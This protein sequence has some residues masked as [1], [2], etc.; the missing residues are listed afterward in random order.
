[1]NT[2]FVTETPNANPLPPQHT[3]PTDDAERRVEQFICDAGLR[4]LAHK[5]QVNLEKQRMPLGLNLFE[6]ISDYYYRETL[7][8][9]ILHAFLDPAGKHQA[10]HTYLY[11]FLEFLRT[12]HSVKID[13]AHYC[14]VVVEKEK[15]RIDIL[16]R[17]EVSKRAIIIENKINGAA[18]QHRQLPGYLEYLEKKGYTCDAIVYLRLTEGAGPDTK[19]WT[20]HDRRQ[21]EAV[22]R[23]VCAYDGSEGEKAL[24]N[25]WILK[26]AAVA[27]DPDTKHILGQYGA[28]IKKLGGD[29]MNKP[30]MEQFYSIIMKDN[31]FKTALSL[32]QML[33]ELV[34]YRVQRIVDLFQS[35]RSPFHRVWPY[36]N[37]ALFSDLPFENGM[38]Q[39]CVWVHE[40]T[41]LF[42]FQHHNR[43]KEVKGQ[44]EV[45][46]REMGVLEEYTFYEHGRFNKTKTFAF[47]SEEQA[48]IDHISTFKRR[49]SETLEALS[50]SAP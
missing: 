1:M 10:Q 38:L 43:E 12:Q 35:D 50:R 42:E 9:N 18:D 31:N 28:I 49:L 29:L 45:I 41:Y 20:N 24:V 33:D 14:K 15:G 21:V 4:E 23:I 7:H 37:G 3:T 44:A 16:I 13:L 32:K 46:L 27:S 8:S 17:D 19:G 48:L 2:P 22:L 26:C 39:I 34:T 30:S 6:L 40:D 5:F 25:G 11:L 47:P 36:E